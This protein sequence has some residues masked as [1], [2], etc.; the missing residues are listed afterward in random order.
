MLA[1]IMESAEM[2]DYLVLEAQKEGLLLFWLL[3]EP[4]AV[5]ISPPLALSEP[6]IKQGCSLILRVLRRYDHSGVN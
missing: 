6:E 4:R 3:F 5:R 2:A 1:L